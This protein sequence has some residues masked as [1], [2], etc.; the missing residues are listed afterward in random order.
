[1]TIHFRNSYFVEIGNIEIKIT[2]AYVPWIGNI[3]F[4]QDVNVRVPL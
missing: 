1:M 2:K 3:G 4:K